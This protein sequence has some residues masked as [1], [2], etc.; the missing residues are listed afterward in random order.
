MSNIFTRAWHVKLTFLL[1]QLPLPLCVENLVKILHLDGFE[2][3]AQKR[4]Q[5]VFFKYANF[6]QHPSPVQI[7]LATLYY[8]THEIYHCW[9]DQFSC[10]SVQSVVKRRDQMSLLKY[11]GSKALL[12]GSHALHSQVTRQQCTALNIH[13]LVV[14]VYMGIFQH[15]KRMTCPLYYILCMVW[16]KIL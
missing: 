14:S 3:P 4:L 8:Y 1:L 12:N 2:F 15:L 9:L 11:K 13:I 10:Y 6:S 16:N 7:W 5:F